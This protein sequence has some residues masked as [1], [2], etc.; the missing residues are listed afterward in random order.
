[1]F[2]LSFSKFSKFSNL[3]FKFFK[4]DQL[5]KHNRWGTF[6]ERSIPID[7]INDPIDMVNPS[8]QGFH[9]IPLF[10]DCF[11]STM[12]CVSHTYY[13]VRQVVELVFSTFPSNHIHFLIHDECRMGHPIYFFH[14]LFR[15]MGSMG[16]IGVIGCIHREDK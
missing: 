16:F 5:G 10:C 3:F 13:T 11:N 8:C 7:L 4:S 9:S 14:I 15:V 1:M 2:C 6:C 12:K